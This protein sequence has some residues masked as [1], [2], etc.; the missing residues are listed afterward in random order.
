MFN[1]NEFKFNIDNIKNDLAIEGMDISQNDI[2]MYKM[3]ANNEIGTI[4]P[5]KEITEIAHAH[6][7]LMHTDAVQAAGNIPVDVKDLGV[8]LMSM[9]GHKIY[10]PKGI[11]SL[12]IRKG[13]RIHNLIH[14]GAQER[15]KR[16]GTENVPAIVGYGKAA[17]MAKN[18]MEN[19]V[20]ELTRL[21]DKLMYGL[22]ERIP[23]TR[24]NGH[25]T[26][27]LPGTANVSFQFIEGEG[28]LLLL[29]QAGIAGSSG[30][31]C[32]SG[33]LDPSHVLMALGLP[34]ELAHGSLRLTVGDFTTDEDIDYILEKL[35]PIIERLRNMSPLWYDFKRK[36]ER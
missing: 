12:Y 11:G 1:E 14:G 24:I 33:S 15:K 29:D 17:E 3:Y 34:H 25:K 26:D 21:R 23:H 10:G 8:D 20:R 4:Q 35:P 36:G 2:D 32:T 22:Q 5:I 7:A 19:H 30:S 9:S 18:N 6:G 27:R 16:A 13:V 31:A 28:I